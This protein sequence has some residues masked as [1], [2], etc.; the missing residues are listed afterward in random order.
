MCY[1]S[2]AIYNDPELSATIAKIKIGD[3]IYCY[4]TMVRN[5]T[6]EAI[7]VNKTYVSLPCSSGILDMIGYIS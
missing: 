1:L 4:M 6:H 2:V 3:K 5:L 7:E